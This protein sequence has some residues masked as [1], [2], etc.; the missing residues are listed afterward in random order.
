L[1]LATRRT[2]LFTVG[3]LL[4]LFQ[5]E[6]SDQHEGADMTQPREKDL[7]HAL[8][9]PSDPQPELQAEVIQDLDLPG[10]DADDLRG[11]KSTCP[12]CLTM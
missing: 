9:E 12:M 1:R 3:L 8:A 6:C 10:D 5:P 11:G 2:T 7:D 4:P